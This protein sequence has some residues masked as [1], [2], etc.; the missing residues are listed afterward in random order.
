MP[1]SGVGLGCLILWLALAAHQLK[2]ILSAATGD[3][4]GVSS[5]INQNS[6]HFQDTLALEKGTDY[7]DRHTLFA[8]N[9][10]SLFQ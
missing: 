6:I 1:L 10:G 2:R 8:H 5:L 9:N 3:T 4:S 7:R